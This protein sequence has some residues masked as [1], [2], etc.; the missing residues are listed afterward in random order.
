[1]GFY[2]LSSDYLHQQIQSDITCVIG[3]VLKIDKASVDGDVEYFAC[4]IDIDLSL[5]FP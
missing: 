4:V 5:D 3:L 1:M 2:G